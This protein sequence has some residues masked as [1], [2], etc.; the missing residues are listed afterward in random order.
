MIKLFVLLTRL[1]VRNVFAPLT[2]GAWFCAS[3]QADAPVEP[4]DNEQHNDQYKGRC[5]K[6]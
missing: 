1:F 4:A 3:A 6:I 5:E 2:E